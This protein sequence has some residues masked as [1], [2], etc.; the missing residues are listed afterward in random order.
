MIKTVQAKSILSP[1]R[2]K[3]FDPFGI[4][5]N[6]NIYRGCQ[7]QCIY[8]DSRSACYQIEDFSDI[9]I[10]EN[11]IDLLKQE[12]P[13]KRKKQTIGTGS[14]N[15]PYMPIEKERGLTR[16]AL[17]LIYR[18]Q[19]PVHI[20]TKSNMVV[21]DLDILRKISKV[22][23]AVSFTITCNDDELA[24]K[25]EP[26]APPPSE[27]FEAMKVLAAAGIYTGIII[28][29]VLPWITDSVENI[30]E[31][32]EHA[33]QVGAR[34]ALSWPGLT[35]RRGQREWFYDQL[36]KHFPGLKEK[37]IDRFGNTYECDSPNAEDL[38]KTYYQICS[39]LRLA[40]KMKFYEPVDPQM[41]LF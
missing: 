28:S 17:E 34:Y 21:R 35:Q 32:L 25:I 11:A 14:M 36:D 33:H 2:S 39:K 15:D 4:A 19:F 9:L 5:Y 10:K 41:A 16:Q 29:P 40:T 3:G 13:A 20:I 12:L 18:Y 31:L 7:H 8:C 1:L 30:R 26:G 24:K 38:N 27:R 22:Y 37:Y 6:M 23:A